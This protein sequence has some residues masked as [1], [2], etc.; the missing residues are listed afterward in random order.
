MRRKQSALSF[1]LVEDITCVISIDV[2]KCTL[3]FPLLVYFLFQSADNW[4]LS[5]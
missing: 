4:A 2:F 5:S 1:E 3:M